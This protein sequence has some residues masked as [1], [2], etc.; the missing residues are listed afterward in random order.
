MSVGSPSIESRMCP[1]LGLHYVHVTEIEEIKEEA[2]KNYSNNRKKQEYAYI[3]YARPAL[4][5]LQ[6]G[7][8]DRA[9]EN[10]GNRNRNRCHETAR[11]D[12]HSEAGKIHFS[13]PLIGVGARRVAFVKES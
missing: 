13:L 3:G 5:A 1:R 9:G 8:V 2:C 10:V 6:V 4:P 7:N 11:D 12:H